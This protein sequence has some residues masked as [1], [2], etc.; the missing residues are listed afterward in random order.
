MIQYGGA[1]VN[2][3]YYLT[4]NGAG[5]MVPQVCRSFLDIFWSDDC[6]VDII[7]LFN[8]FSFQMFF[9][10][11]FSNLFFDYLNW[12]SSNSRF[13]VV[14]VSKRAYFYTS[15]GPLWLWVFFSFFFFPLFYLLVKASPSVGDDYSFHLR[16]KV[17]DFAHNNAKKSKVFFKRWI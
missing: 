2:E 7:F 4:V 8:T 3:F 17:L 15:L 6:V 14:T 13:F 11:I 9:V 16:A 1:N 5:H 10:I 12:F